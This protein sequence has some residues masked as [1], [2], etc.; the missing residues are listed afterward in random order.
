MARG[1]QKESDQAFGNDNGS[2]TRN[3]QIISLSLYPV[4]YIVGPEDQSHAGIRCF[5]RSRTGEGWEPQP[6]TCD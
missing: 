2:R 1:L 5:K 6:L 4:S 3:L